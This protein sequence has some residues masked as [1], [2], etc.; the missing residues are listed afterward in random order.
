MP[1]VPT[2][3]STNLFRGTRPDPSGR[4]PQGDDQPLASNTQL[5][6]EVQVDWID[7]DG[8]PAP[9]LAPIDIQDKPVQLQIPR[10]AWMGDA[11]IQGSSLKWSQ[12]ARL[13]LINVPKRINKEESQFLAIDVDDAPRMLSQFVRFADLSE[14][15]LERFRSRQMRAA[16]T[17][18][19]D[20]G[21]QTYYA[22]KPDELKEKESL[23][24]QQGSSRI[25]IFRSTPRLEFQLAIDGFPSDLDQGQ[26]PIE[27][28]FDD[29]PQVSIYGDRETRCRC[30]IDQSNII[31]NSTLS[32][33]VLSLDTQI[34]NNRVP[35]SLWRSG[36]RLNNQEELELIFDTEKPR[37]ER[38][39]WNPA[40]VEQGTPAKCQYTVNDRS[41]SGVLSKQLLV[42]RATSKAMAEEFDVAGD[43]H[44]FPT[45]KLEP[46]DY[47]TWLKVVDR[48]GNETESTIERLR[49]RPKPPPPPPPSSNPPAGGKP[50][51][52]TADKA[53]AAPK[54]KLGKLNGVAKLP[55]GGA[56]SVSSGLKITLESTGD[57]ATSP[58]FEFKD[59]PLQD[60]K[61][62]ATCEES[63][64]KYKL[65][66]RFAC[67]RNRISTKRSN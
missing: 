44:F 22:L 12:P 9:D 47:D 40:S 58:R 60:T 11:G 65:K 23:F 14:Q 18:V 30:R 62:T 56:P 55:Y 20:P 57:T 29:S 15:P 42:K 67:G 61:I 59:V 48:A 38:F 31:L 3:D 43:Q 26:E 51:S 2:I 39:G 45:D 24:Y 5:D 10:Q 21:K 36:R 66:R 7:I 4:V 27:V 37:I 41:L 25:A 52:D 6:L 17:Q 50:A 34:S 54:P 8:E 64:T 46:G 53:P 32:D 16:I 33:V 63:G 35:V 19:R 28:R 1:I 49:V 13:R